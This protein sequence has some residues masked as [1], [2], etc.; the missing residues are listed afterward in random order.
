MMRQAFD[1][2]GETRN[3]LTMAVEVLFRREQRGVKKLYE[4]VEFMSVELH[5]RRSEEQQ[6][7]C[8]VFHRRKF[9]Y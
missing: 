5:R 8:Q 2:I 7:S 4:G 6:P 3:C 1:E 9:V